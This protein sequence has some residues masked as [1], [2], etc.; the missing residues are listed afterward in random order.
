MKTWMTYGFDKIIVDMP[1]PEKLDKELALYLTKGGK[2]SCQIVFVGD[3][4]AGSKFFVGA[5]H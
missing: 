3:L 2:G 5:E 1:A 4:V